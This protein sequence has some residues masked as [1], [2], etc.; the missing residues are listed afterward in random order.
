MCVD[1][2]RYLIGGISGIEKLMALYKNDVFRVEEEES[3]TSQTPC[4]HWD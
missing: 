3:A 1:L 2:N 4:W